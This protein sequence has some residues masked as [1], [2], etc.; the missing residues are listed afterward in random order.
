LVGSYKAPDIWLKNKVTKRSH[1]IRKGLPDA[2]DLL[3]VNGKA[4]RILKEN[5]E[6]VGLMGASM[7]QM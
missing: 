5:G 6:R 1:A 7:K 2:L 3:I 4:T